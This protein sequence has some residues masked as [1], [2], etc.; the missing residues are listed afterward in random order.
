M[1]SDRDFFRA[2]VDALSVLG[3]PNVDLVI[4]ALERDKIIL[5]GVVDRNKLE[6]ALRS[7]FGDGAKVFLEFTK[8]AKT[9]Q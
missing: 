2:L 8:R 4:Q 7:I 6:P 9:T 1:I 5:D 3:K